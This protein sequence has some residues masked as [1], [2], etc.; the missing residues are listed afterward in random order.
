MPT[1]IGSLASLITNYISKH[2]RSAAI[3]DGLEY[4]TIN[5]GFG[6]IL[7]FV[8]HVNEAVMRSRCTM[9]IPISPDAMDR[10]EL[11]LIERNTEVIESPMIYIQ[12]ED[13]GDPLAQ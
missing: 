11:A 8:E 6:Q 4:L 12:M 10:K 5:N 9:I 2:E 1:D 13:A 7:K 3:L